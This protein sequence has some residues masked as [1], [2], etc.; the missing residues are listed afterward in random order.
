MLNRGSGAVR[1]AMFRDVPDLTMPGDVLVVNNTRVTALRLH[2]QK[3]TGGSIE[4]LLLHPSAHPRSFV[5]LM[6]PGKRLRPGT[7]LEFPGA[8]TAS[9]TRDLGDG[10]KE[11]LF[12]EQAHLSDL[13]IE[14]GEVPLPPYITA[15]L[16]EAERYQTVY[17]E[18]PGS[19]AAPT[20]GLHFTPE[21][22]EKLRANGVQIAQVTLSVGIDT[23]RPV[24]VEDLSQHQMHGERCSI[25]EQSAET[26]NSATGRI[27]A[28]GTTSVRTLESF[29]ASKRGVSPGEQTTKIFIKPGYDWQV[30]DAMFTNFHLPKTTMLMMLAAMV[31]REPLLAAYRHAVAQQY[32]F[33]SFGDS[34]LIE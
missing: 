26:I 4:A 10:L 5:A 29:A 6:K 17:S 28:V 21:L 15:Q 8:M 31:G 3:S 9:V 11:V 25:S 24:A 19:S 12:D 18:A 20:A 23:F 13:L 27:I 7:R 16:D 33:L 1:D 34:M 2:G 30:V 32:R 14:H 22:L